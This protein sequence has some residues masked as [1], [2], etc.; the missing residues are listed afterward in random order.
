MVLA[1]RLLAFTGMRRTEVLTLKWEYL[2][3]DRSCLHLPDSKTGKKTVQIAAPPAL[4]LL[5][6]ASRTEDNPYVCPGER[7]GARLIGIDKE[8]RRIRNRAKLESIRL[9]DLTPLC[10]VPDYAERAAVCR[11]KWLIVR[12]FQICRIER[13][14]IIHGH[15]E[16]GAGLRSPS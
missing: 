11:R 12:S 14:G 13:L 6:K 9:H 3:A 15:V 2:D 16:A 7:P 10:R 8:W 5:L 4:E 1:I